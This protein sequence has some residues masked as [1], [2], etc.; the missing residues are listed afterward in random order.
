MADT[1]KEGRAFAVPSYTYAQLSAQRFPKSTAKSEPA[2]VRDLTGVW[3]AHPTEENRPFYLFTF[4][5][6]EPVLTPWALE[7]Y[8]RKPGPRITVRSRSKP[9]TTRC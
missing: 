6:D 2:P 9:P 3:M 5:K 1:F 8:K 7:K 4:T